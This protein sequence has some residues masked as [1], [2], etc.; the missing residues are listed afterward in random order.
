MYESGRTDDR[1]QGPED[2]V[3][4]VDTYTRPPFLGGEVMGDFRRD[5][6]RICSICRVVVM[7]VFSPSLGFLD[8]EEV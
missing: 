8:A 3:S 4:S 1:D 6:V 2:E 5:P 7:L